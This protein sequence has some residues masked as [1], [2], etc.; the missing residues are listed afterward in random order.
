MHSEIFM[1]VFMESGRLPDKSWDKW[2]GLIAKR[3]EK[4]LSDKL[5]LN[6]LRL[7][8]SPRKMVR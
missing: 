4:A 3:F 6:F 1:A 5:P 7:A 2:A 8:N